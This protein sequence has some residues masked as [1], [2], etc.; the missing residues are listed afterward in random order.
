MSKVLFD[1]YSLIHKESQ[2]YNGK[3]KDM[4]HNAIFVSAYSKR[5]LVMILLTSLYTVLHENS[6]GTIRDSLD[7]I[8]RCWEQSIHLYMEKAKKNSMLR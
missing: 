1:I 3:S 2:Q 8:I 6:M 7:G 5:I 4:L